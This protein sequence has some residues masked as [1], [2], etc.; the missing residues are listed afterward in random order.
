[1]HVHRFTWPL[2]HAEVRAHDVTDVA[3]GIKGKD[4]V[5]WHRLM[6]IHDTAGYAAGIYW[7]L[8]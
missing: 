7:L 2:P 3:P 8:D 6:S 1:M 5:I 4:T